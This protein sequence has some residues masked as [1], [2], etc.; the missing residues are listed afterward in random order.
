MKKFKQSLEAHG[1]LFPQDLIKN[2]AYDAFQYF[3]GVPPKDDIAMLAIRF[4]TEAEKQKRQ[5]D[6]QKNVVDVPK[7]A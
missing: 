4:L 2:T 6:E 5:E 3:D 7:V 1:T